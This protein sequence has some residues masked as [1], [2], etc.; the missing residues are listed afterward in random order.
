MHRLLAK[1][2]FIEEKL[3]L[4]ATP[5]WV[6]CEDLFLRQI[7]RDLA[8]LPSNWDV[9]SHRIH[10]TEACLTSSSKYCR[11]WGASVKPQTVF[12]L[13][14]KSHLPICRRKSRMVSSLSVPLA[15][16]RQRKDGELEIMMTTTWLGKWAP[17]SF[18]FGVFLKPF[19]H[20]TMKQN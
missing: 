16:K 1:K 3:V 2:N 12:Y 11:E 19:K 13:T 20:S 7:L 10:T 17:I 5:S 4:L 9:I 18:N 8:C 14:K 6:H 15:A